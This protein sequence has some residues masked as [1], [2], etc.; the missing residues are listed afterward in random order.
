MRKNHG[1]AHDLIGVLRVDTQIDGQFDGFVKLRVVRLLNQLACFRELVRMRFHL[2]ARI[3]YM[4]S[5]F[6]SLLLP[7]RS[8]SAC[9]SL[10]FHDFQTHVA[11]RT[12]DGA[13]RGVQ[14]CGV[15]I[16]KL[17]LRNFYNLLFRDFADFV[18]IRFRRALG[19]A[20]RAQQQEWK[21]AA[22]SE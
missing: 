15:E 22:S 20:R 5:S 16:D 11:R 7:L 6:L 8:L 9:N 17:D 3:L 19:D 12:H 2:L 21:P 4:F 1:A 18:A 10:G 14:I 13:H